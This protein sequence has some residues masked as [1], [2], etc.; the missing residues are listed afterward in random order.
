MG[1]SCAGCLPGFGRLAA[2]LECRAEAIETR[3]P[4]LPVTGEPGIDLA[5]RLRPQRIQAALPVRP[6]RDETRLVQDAQVPRDA[7]LMDAG[8]LD[9]VVDLPLAA[10]Q[11]LD[12]A[13][14]RRIGQGLEWI[15]MH[16]YVYALKCI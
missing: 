15:Q 1:C 13:A 7:G 2:L 3:L 8:F 10:A 6:H 12:D 4:Q 16:E 11:R 9:D 14:P 5:E